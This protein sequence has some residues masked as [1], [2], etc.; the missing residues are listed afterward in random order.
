M[1]NMENFQVDSRPWEFKAEVTGSEFLQ[2]PNIHMLIYP[3]INFQT[4]DLARD[5]AGWRMTVSQTK[6]YRTRR[7]PQITKAKVVFSRIG[8]TNS[9]ISLRMNRDTIYKH[10]GEVFADLQ[11]NEFHVR[12]NRLKLESFEPIVV[13]Q[14]AAEKPSLRELLDQYGDAEILALMNERARA[15]LDMSPDMAEI[16]QKAEDFLDHFLKVA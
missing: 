12:S 14:Q 10:I 1:A 13:M 9:Y 8:A 15:N 4:H 3:M 2:L 7:T 5:T 16:D 11:R 6:Y